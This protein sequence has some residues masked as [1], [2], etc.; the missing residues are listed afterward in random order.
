MSKSHH[1]NASLSSPCCQNHPPG[2]T[3]ALHRRS[4]SGPR[5]HAPPQPPSSLWRCCCY[6]CCCTWF[7]QRQHQHQGAAGQPPPSNVAQQQRRTRSAA[8]RA[9]THRCAPALPALPPALPMEH[10]WSARQAAPLRRQG[11]APLTACMHLHQRHAQHVA[12]MPRATPLRQVAAAAVGGIA[13]PQP[14]SCMYTT[15]YNVLIMTRVPP[16]HPTCLPPSCCPAGSS[17]TTHIARRPHLLGSAAQHCT[18]LNDACQSSS[19]APCWGRD[20][21]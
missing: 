4:P 5:A 3:P 12:P 20:S 19:K 21:D 16:A 11:R 6:G 13:P 8:H 10:P 17:S 7:H 2:N 14:C 1:S 15:L 18:V 9:A